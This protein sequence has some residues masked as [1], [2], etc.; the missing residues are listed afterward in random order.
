[1]QYLYLMTFLIN[2]GFW[3]NHDEV[4][5][6]FFDFNVPS[7]NSGYTIEAAANVE[8]FFILWKLKSIWLQVDCLHIK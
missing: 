5:L 8:L 7:E 1:M 6:D 2:I 3:V 4:P